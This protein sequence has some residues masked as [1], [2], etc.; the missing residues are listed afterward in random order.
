LVERALKRFRNRCFK[1]NASDAFN[2]WK[3]SINR[4][5]EAHKDD[6]LDDM[7]KKDSEFLEFVDKT[8]ETNLNRCYNHFMEKNKSNLWKAW[9]NV[10]K[11]IKLTKAKTKEFQ[12]RALIIRRKD[13]IDHWK[14]RVERTKNCRAKNNNLVNQ[15][16]FK[17]FRAAFYAL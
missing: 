9:V 4:N 2:R 14:A 15:F 7:K 5:V 17:Y 3:A 12:K 10:I 6:V 1:N 11:S 16:K 13:A 8:K